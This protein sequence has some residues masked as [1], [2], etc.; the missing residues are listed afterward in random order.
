MSLTTPSS[1]KNERATFRMRNS[2][3]YSLTTL[4]PSTRVKATSWNAPPQNN[5]TTDLRVTLGLAE[6]SPP[7]GIGGRR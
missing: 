7:M 6:P 4:H 3:S 2:Q 5:P 1:G